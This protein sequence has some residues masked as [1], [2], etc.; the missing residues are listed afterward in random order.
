[1]KP[2]HRKG[3]AHDLRWR[4]GG[5]VFATLVVVGSVC[6]AWTLQSIRASAEQ[7]ARQDAHSIAQ[8]EAQTLAQQLGRAVRL[9]IP[10][11]ALPGVQEYLQTMLERQPLL[12]GIVIEAPD[13]QAWYQAA[14]GASKAVA[15][16]ALPARVAIPAGA[17]PAGAV[18]VSVAG[19]EGQ[20]QGQTLLMALGAVL[21]LALCGGLG[22]AMGPGARLEGQ[23]RAALA[24][25]REG[26]PQTLPTDLADAE[27]PQAMLQAL[28]QGEEQVQAA[29][30]D[31]QAYAQE[32][33][34]MDFDGQMRADIERVAREAATVKGA[35]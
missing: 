16:D 2:E 18:V 15:K 4:L 27:G 10:L 30:E 22:A 9:G 31:V 24:W 34:A 35:P 6:A 7:A 29:R 17:S 21:G 20:G 13:G 19:T 12:S 28:V 5:L 32:L 25:L 26:P 33:L 11:Q 14:R 1:M 23:R 8:S 3:M